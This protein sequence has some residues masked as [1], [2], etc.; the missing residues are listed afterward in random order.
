[1]VDLRGRLF[2]SCDH[3]KE[4]DHSADGGE[5]LTWELFTI[6]PWAISSVSRFRSWLLLS[7]RGPQSPAVLLDPVFKILDMI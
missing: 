3:C 4:V 7:L 6:I 2:W 1:M 5:K